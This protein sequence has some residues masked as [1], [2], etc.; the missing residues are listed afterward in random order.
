MADDVTL[1]FNIGENGSSFYARTI[2]TDVMWDNS[3]VV[4]V[5]YVELP[6]CNPDDC[7]EIEYRCA[8]SENKSYYPFIARYQ[9]FSN[10][11][12]LKY[13]KVFY[14]SPGSGR[15]S[16]IPNRVAKNPYNGNYLL[17][18]RW[19]GNSAYNDKGVPG[20]C[21][22]GPNLVGSDLDVKQIRS[23]AH[24][25]G[26]LHQLIPYDNDKFIIVGNTLTDYNEYDGLIL[27]LDD[28]Y[29]MLNWRL[30]I[31]P[32]HDHNIKIKDITST[33]AE[34]QYVI[35][36]EFGKAFASRLRI[37]PGNAA[38]IQF[39]LVKTGECFDEDISREYP[40]MDEPHSVLNDG[41]NT[42][43]IGNKIVPGP[44]GL[45]T[46]VNTKISTDKL[47]TA[48]CDD[49]LEVNLYRVGL[50]KN[51]FRVADLEIIEFPLEAVNDIFETQPLTI[52]ESDPCQEE[53]VPNE[54]SVGGILE[55]YEGAMGHVKVF[56]NPSKDWIIVES[57]FA[58]R[59]FTLL[60][61]EGREIR[62]EK[63]SGKEILVSLENLDEGSYILKVRNETGWTNE[64]IVKE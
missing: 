13:K 38:P 4:V 44:W 27:V 1:R 41:N 52:N 53:G 16:F 28:N 64:L 46:G 7:E 20:I 50:N 51:F 19:F 24:F 58:I 56:P 9:W 5:G 22:L 54:N 31:D 60:N 6:Q 45:N 48:N 33:C 43:I 55:T 57:P 39:S 3:D 29:N 63:V 36:G 14:N 23:Y 47:L 49:P 8:S 62:N 18:G 42:I 15:E 26:E 37:Q 40:Y 12:N 30:I 10:T 2:A 59:E 17:V 21:E 61:I 32:N 11:L 34:N 25:E 35:T